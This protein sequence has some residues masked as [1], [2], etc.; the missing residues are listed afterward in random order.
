MAIVKLFMNP[1]RP[2]KGPLSTMVGSPA[3][4]RGGRYGAETEAI[5]ALQDQINAINVILKMKGVIEVDLPS[6]DPG[7]GRIWYD[8]GDGNRVKFTP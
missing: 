6:A 4:P 5:E 3:L 2:A 1:L 8:P 7:S